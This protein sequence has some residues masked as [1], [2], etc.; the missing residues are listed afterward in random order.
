[1]THPLDEP[2][3]RKSAAELVSDRLMQLIVAG[4]L[5]AGEPLRETQLAERLGIS[6]NSL[7]EGIRL[8][9]RSRLVKYEMHRGAI[10]SDPS[11]ADLDD[12]YRTRRHLETA[13]VRAV[14]TEGGL[15]Q[16]RRAWEHLEASTSVPAAEPIV[17]AD[18]ALHQAIV[19]LLDSERISAFYASICKELVFYFS[20]LSHA[21]EEYRY[22]Q[23]PIVER[24]REIVE[25]ILERRVADAE[26]LT[27]QHI[28]ENQARLTDILRA[29]A[30]A[31]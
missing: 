24:H 14:P 13:A 9:E 1:M 29:R 5:E 3:H 11:L 30:A 20:V 15:N 31:A 25:A 17:A 6:R 10:V 28:D 12:L 18:L 7:R 21:D 26:R 4:V 2:L 16:L 22:P 8:L 23:T 27:L 19:G